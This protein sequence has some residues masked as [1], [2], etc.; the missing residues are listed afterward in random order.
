MANIVTHAQNM[1]VVH[2]EGCRAYKILAAGDTAMDDMYQATG[3]A[4]Y[5]ANYPWER[6]SLS[7]KAGCCNEEL[8]E[9]SRRRGLSSR[10]TVKEHV[11]TCEVQSAA[12]TFC[13]RGVLLIN[14]CDL[15]NV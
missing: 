4:V 3:L 8:F 13:R 7:I 9:D 6:A 15:L 11:G 12:C 5:F 14:L 1:C 10:C 2:V